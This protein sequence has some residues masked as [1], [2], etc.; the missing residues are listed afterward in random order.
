VPTHAERQRFMR[1]YQRLTREQRKAFLTAVGLF[2]AGLAVKEFD[3]RLRVKRVQGQRGVWELTW[4]PDGR[5]TFGRAIRTSSGGESARTTSSAN[6][7]AQDAQ[8]EP[9]LRER[10]D[11]RPLAMGNPEARYPSIDRPAA[12][13]LG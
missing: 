7:R 8:T 10:A 5:A 2:V 6:P 4:A 3:P 9:P 12:R 1:E 13:P 11:S